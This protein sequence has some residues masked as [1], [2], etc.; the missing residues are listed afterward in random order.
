[1]LAAEYGLRQENR[2]LVNEK[3]DRKNNNFKFNNNSM[4]RC[5]ILPGT[6]GLVSE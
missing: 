6:F 4:C 1:M 5:D 2:G 3:T